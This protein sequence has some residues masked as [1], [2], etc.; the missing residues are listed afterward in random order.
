MQREGFR[1]TAEFEDAHW[2]FRSRR[3]LIEAQLRRAAAEIAPA[4]AGLRLLD[5]GCGTGRNLELLARFGEA[6]GADVPS[7]HAAEF[8]RPAPA[9]ILDLSGDLRA[10]HGRF[11]VLTALDVLEHTRDDAA[12]LREMARFLA[13][14]GQLILTVP[15]HAWLWSDEDVISEH[16]RRYSRGSLADACRRA[17]LVVRFLSHFN[18]GILPAAALWVGSRRLF[19]RGS[20]PRSNL[21]ASPGS[22]NALLYRLTSAEARAVGGES[23][24]L[25]A[26]ASLVCRCTVAP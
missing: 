1:V 20:E 5:Y 21:E 11:H 3:D 22:W 10:Q 25:P 14:G 24:R 23:L 17:G 26:G 6:W 4:S 9:P 7:P 18:L 8:R 2:W 19:A 15:A 13:P 16:E 12:A